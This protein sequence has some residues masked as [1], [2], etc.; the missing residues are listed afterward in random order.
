MEA[1]KAYTEFFFSH[2]DVS[3]IIATIREENRASWNV[4]EKGR[5]QLMDKKM[6]K[7]LNDEKAE[8]YRFYEFRR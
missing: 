3:G 5:F 6:Y 1:V 4:V 8:M 7:D 2:Y